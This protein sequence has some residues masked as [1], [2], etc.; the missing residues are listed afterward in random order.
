MQRTYR[1][2]LERLAEGE[3]SRT[4]LAQPFSISVPAISKHLRT[5]EHAEPMLHHRARRT[6]RCG[7]GTG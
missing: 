3:A 6:H 5:P 7:W 1:V 2:L 4:Q